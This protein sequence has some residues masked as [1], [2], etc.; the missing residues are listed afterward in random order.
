MS[1][2]K[3]IKAAIKAELDGKTAAGDRVYVTMDRPINPAD[4][5]IIVIYITAAKRGEQ[6]F[7]RGLTTRMVTVQV[8]AALAVDDPYKAEQVAE[9]FADQVETIL[10]ADQ[11]WHN[12][13]QNSTWLGTVTDVSSIGEVVVANVLLE[14]QVEYLND[15]KG[16]EFLGVR[17]D[18]FD[19]PPTNVTT[20]PD[21]D[22]TDDAFFRPRPKPPADT[23]CD[24][25]NGCNI[26]AWQGEQ[27]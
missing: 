10:G 11:S 8:E 22:L 14:Y 16:E 4:L 25:V 1:Y 13:V 19:Q 3:A 27:N 20:R 26:P 9:D 12:Q 17:D 5:P 21:V 18:G 23:A 15:L 7:G 2:R 6:E 24:P